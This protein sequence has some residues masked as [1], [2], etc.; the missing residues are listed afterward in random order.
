MR[1]FVIALAFLAIWQPAL[2]QTLPD[3]PK[4]VVDGYAEVRTM[5]DV[6]T[7]GYTL[8]GEGTTSDEA[9]KAMVAMGSKIHAMLRTVEPGIEP[10][11]DDV[12]VTPVKGSACRDRDYDSDDQLSKGACAVVG[13]IATQSVTVRTTDIADAGTMVGLAGRG[14]AYDARI[15]GFAL[16]DP[17]PAKQQAFAAALTDAQSKAAALAAGSRVNLGPILTIA[18]GDRAVTVLSSQDIRLSATTRSEDLISS[19]PQGFAKPVVVSVTPEPI[20][21]S[22]TVGVTYAIAR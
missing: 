6:A 3:Q 17:R 4:I 21:T 18:M 22:A 7:I 11:S 19:L 1:K 14:G 16:S 10:K 12:R 2:A 20:T 8:R 9:V 5:P 13:H 15:Q